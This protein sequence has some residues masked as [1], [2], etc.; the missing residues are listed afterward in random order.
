MTQIVPQTERERWPNEPARQMLPANF[1]FVH[2]TDVA[3]LGPNFL[4]VT[5]E[6][7]DVSSH[8][9]DA[10]HFRLVQPP[11]ESA[12]TWPSVA[13]NGSILWPEG[14]G[15]PHR[16]VYTT[17]FVDYRANTLVTDIFIHDGGR[18]TEW[19]QEL[20]RGGRSR[21]RVGLVGPSGG[22]L[23]H[24]DR[25]LMATDETGFPAAARILDALPS[26]AVGDL[27]L[28]AEHGAA[29]AYPITAPKGVSVYWLGRAQGD[30]VADAALSV[31]SLH[32]G[33]KI[34]FVGERE[35]ARR[36]REAG[37]AAGREPADLRVSGFWRKEPDGPSSK[38]ARQKNT[39]QP[40]DRP[41]LA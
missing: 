37:K 29:C 33:S 16:P 1:M 6:G 34:W 5:L 10:I 32:R 9:D 41:V 22:G 24:A 15:A 21:S 40:H 2:V 25:V 38:P 14:P 4:R 26:H 11:I 27:F 8:Q 35:E 17:R 13:A 12:P 23:M 28:E 19:A 39:G 7:E 31:L 3:P 36:V 18:T 30:N 20:Q